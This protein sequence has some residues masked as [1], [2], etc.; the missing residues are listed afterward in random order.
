TA[1]AEGSLSSDA[2]DRRSTIPH[3]AAMEAAVLEAGLDAIAVRGEGWNETL[4]SWARIELN[5]LT[6]RTAIH[7]QHPAYTV[8]SMMYEPQKWMNAKIFP[9]EHPRV[10]EIMG[11]E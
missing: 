3:D 8:L 9:V 4:L 11:F 1:K 5:E 6:G 10:A 2:A 7:G